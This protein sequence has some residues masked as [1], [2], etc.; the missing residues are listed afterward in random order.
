MSATSAGNTVS[1]PC[2]EG[3]A[4]ENIAS[5]PFGSMRDL[6]LFLAHAAGRFEEHRKPD[7][8]QLAARFAA[9]R[10]VSKP[11]QSAACSAVSSRRAGS[12]LS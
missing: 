9:L 3:P 5:W 2:P 4:R 7:A 6:D 10:R 11:S 1:C 12:A 8:A